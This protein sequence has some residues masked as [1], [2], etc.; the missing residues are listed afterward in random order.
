MQLD[1][2]VTTELQ[3]SSARERIKREVASPPTSRSLFVVH[4]EPDG[5]FVRGKLL[6]T[7]GLEE[8]QVLLTSELPLGELTLDALE[9]GVAASELTVVIVSAAYLADRLAQ[10][11]EQLA[12]YAELEGG[13]RLVP[14]VLDRG[15]PSLRIRAK[16]SLDLCDPADW[17]AEL[18]RLAQ[19]LGQP[20]AAVEDIPCPYPGLRSLAR[21]DAGKL[22]GRDRELHEILARV[23]TGE[24]ELHL[25]GP[26]GSGKSSLVA[27]GVLPKLAAGRAQIRGAV[28]RWFRP[29]DAPLQRLREA[30]QPEMKGDGRATTSL[31]W[32]GETELKDELRDGI[33]ALLRDHPDEHRLV[34]HIDQLEEVFTLAGEAEREQ[35]FAA[36]EIVRADRRCL[37]FYCLRADFFDEL[38]ISPLW[39][40]GARCV[41]I[42]PLRGESLREAIECPASEAGVYL[43]PRLVERLV[44]DARGASGI[45]PLVQE[46][47][48]QLWEQRRHRVLSLSCYE[49]MGEA[50]RSGLAVAMSRRA[51]AC[52]AELSPARKKI[53][54]RI[55]LRL[56]HFGEGAADTRCQRAR[57]ELA[58]EGE[59]RAELE[60]VLEHLMKGRLVTADSNPGRSK[61]RAGRVDLVHEALIEAWEQLGSWIQATRADGQRHRQLENA[62]ASW[63]ALGRGE[64]GLLHDGELASALAWRKTEAARELGQSAELGALFEAS[65][66]AQRKRRRRGRFSLA[67][68]AALGLVA[69]AL[70]LL[71]SRQGAELEREREAV[72]VHRAFGADMARLSTEQQAQREQAL[73]G[74]ELVAGRPLRALSHLLAARR[75]GDPSELNAALGFMYHQAQKVRPEASMRVGGEVSAVAV[76]PDGTLAAVAAKAGAVRVRRIADGEIETLSLQHEG[77]VL[78]LA[79]SPDGQR[80]VTGGN[81]RTARIWSSRGAQLGTLQHGGAVWSVAFNHDGSELVTGSGDGKAQIWN[82]ATKKLVSLPLEHGSVVQSVRFGTNG[83]VATGGTDHY[84]RVWRVV[85]GK[86]S[87]VWSR[88]FK[89]AVTSVELSPDETRALVVAGDAGAHLIELS[90]GESHELRHPQG[91]SSAAFGAEGAYIVTTG[92]DHSARLWAVQSGEAVGAIMWHSG[93]VRSAVFSGSGARLLTVSADKTA[94]LWDVP[95]GMSLSA[96]FEHD[97]AVSLAAIDREG[98]QLLIGGPSG[99]RLWAAE[100]DGREHRELAHQGKV[101]SV[102]FLAKSNQVIVADS[103]QGAIWWDMERGAKLKTFAYADEELRLTV[104]RDD[105]WLATAAAD[106]VKLWALA[107]EEMRAL[108]AVHRGDVLDLAFSRDGKYLATGSGDSTAVIWD[109]EAGKNVATLQH[110]DAVT[111][112]TFHPDGVVLATATAGGEVALWDRVSGQR[113]G[114]GAKEHKKDVSGLDVTPDGQRLVSADE[115]GRV[116]VWK[117]VGSSLVRERVLDHPNKKV[118]CVRV[119][120]DG[121]LIATASRDKRVRIWNVEGGAQL[122][123]RRYIDFVRSLA[124][125]ANGAWLVT[126]GNDGEVRLWDVARNADSLERWQEVV[127]K[128]EVAD[129]P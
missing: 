41:T 124:W 74:Q 56:V 29:G 71:W 3:S 122:V 79:I 39:G 61:K 97:D 99:A 67:G 33:D 30:L 115:E 76:S 113:L 1:P 53:A 123:E 82:V 77:G 36:L 106:G 2:M 126:G 64:G 20:V 27:A 102:A 62:A 94:Q 107:G 120:P 32:I 81:D 73:A 13:G 31:P 109:V 63:A 110:A 70:L 87:A 68:L 17:D 5:W 37:L 40:E 49:R 12:C 108:P 44:A 83:V 96:S 11:T 19:L 89:D 46:T 116:V 65:T 101:R 129:A 117:V 128:S 66:R 105:R 91:A 9:R 47:L 60:A 22:F 84:A 50:G 28:V 103:T 16:V 51:D 121:A 80:L 118:H 58:L 85:E 111:S 15:A 100:I 127:E 90:T 4:A 125:S 14:L 72:G 78:S 57:D 114:V 104:S 95:S 93:A 38:I 23:K 54:R 24:R 10:Y 35:F 43:E 88:K 34:L 45:L 59:P 6:P 25:I 98:R 112:L 42:A 18:A 8:D 92:A 69:G 75:A 21:E 7:L 119:S 55:L 26:S 86:P 48:L 52:L